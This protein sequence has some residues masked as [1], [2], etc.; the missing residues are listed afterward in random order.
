MTPFELVE[1]ASLKEAITLLE[2]D[3][4]TVRPIAGG[5]ALMLMMKAGVFRPTRLV[6]LRKLA[7]QLG[8]IATAAKGALAIGAMTP[9]AE[10]ERS[11]EVARAAPVIPRAM[12]RLSNI[13]V[14]NVATVG[15]NLAHGDPH[16]DLPPIL[17]AL[18]AEVAVA[19]PTGQRTIALEHLFAGY[20]ETVLAKNELIVELRIPAQGNTR[21]AYVKVTTGSAE[22]W[23][24]LGVAVALETAGAAMKSARVVVSAATEK[25]VR[26]ANAEAALA[27]A[28]ADDA[29]LARA[30]DAAAAEAECVSDVRGSAVYKRELIR[31]HVRRAIRQAL[32][33]GAHGNGTRR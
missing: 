23:P 9:L 4:P 32:D 31:V 13:R 19:G 17:I 5:T 18:G 8:R 10:V 20:F 12:R 21:A 24:A 25:A 33:Q 3:D 16:M 15:G 14:R 11:A 1:P 27:G 6:S 22:D 26:L 28:A 29:T 2:P 7:P 30:A